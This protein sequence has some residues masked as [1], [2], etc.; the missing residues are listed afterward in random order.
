MAC[1]V[2]RANGRDVPP[3]VSPD[4]HG[5]ALIATRLWPTGQF[6]FRQGWSGFVAADG[7][8]GMKWGWHRA[9]RGQL[10]IDGRRLDNLRRLFERRSRQAKATSAF[11]RRR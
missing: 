4:L 1:N 6:V 7:A 11:S 5:N 3:Q 2:T 9:V 8:L 10:R